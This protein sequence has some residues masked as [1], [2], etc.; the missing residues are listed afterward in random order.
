M[1][2]SRSRATG[3]TSPSRHEVR[4]CIPRASTRW[5]TSSLARARSAAGADCRYGHQGADRINPGSGADTVLAGRGN[6]R[7]NTGGS[8]A[9]TIDCG[10][11]K[12]DVAL[13]DEHD[14]TRRCERVRTG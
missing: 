3:A 12:R 11:G 5:W 6:D 14:T 9:D 1:P 7:V 10:R 13:V 8:I 4:T 2:T